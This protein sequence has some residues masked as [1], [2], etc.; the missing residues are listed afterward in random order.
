MSKGDNKSQTP[1]WKKALAVVLTGVIIAIAPQFATI[2]P[3]ISDAVVEVF[4]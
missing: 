2:A 1:K 4:E 3:A